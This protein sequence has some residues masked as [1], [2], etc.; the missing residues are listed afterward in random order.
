MFSEHLLYFKHLTWFSDEHRAGPRGR[1]CVE[2]Y[3]LDTKVTA[4]NASSRVV[5]CPGHPESCLL[6][7]MI[8]DVTPFHSLIALV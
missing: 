3:Q 7:R 4:T 8:I 5:I 1:H 2:L 6:P